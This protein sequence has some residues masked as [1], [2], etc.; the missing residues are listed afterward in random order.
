M[1]LKT[2]LTAMAGPLAIG[3]FLVST[4]QPSSSL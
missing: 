3:A 1:T 4:D 2:D